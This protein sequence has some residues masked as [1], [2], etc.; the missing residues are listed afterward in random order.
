[1]LGTEG[2]DYISPKKQLYPEGKYKNLDLLSEN[3]I[4][5]GSAVF[6][7]ASDFVFPDWIYPLPYADWPLHLQ[8]AEEG[9]IWLDDSVMGARRLHAGG[10][11]TS[12]TLR[13]QRRNDHLIVKAYSENCSPKL[14]PAAKKRADELME[15]TLAN[16]REMKSADV[17]LLRGLL[18]SKQNRSDALEAYTE[19]TGENAS[20]LLVFTATLKNFWEMG[21]GK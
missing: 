9:C 14:R 19:I 21:R 2:K 6:R 8:N 11:Y 5:S 4:P 16:D 7:R 20:R 3:F 17:K 12:L 1:V 13:A 15:L 18:K 10:M